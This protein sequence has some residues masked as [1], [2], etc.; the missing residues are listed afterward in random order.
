MNIADL[1]KKNF[2]LVPE[3]KNAFKKVYSFI[4]DKFNKQILINVIRQG[5]RGRLLSPG[6][7]YENNTRRNNR[8]E[9]TNK[10]NN[11]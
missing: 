9:T 6:T 7:N 4:F 11:R 1:L 5:G 10:K 2:I 8:Y 3:I